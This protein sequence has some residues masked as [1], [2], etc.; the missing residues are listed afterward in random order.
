MGVTGTRMHI[1]MVEYDDAWK[2]VAGNS[3]QLDKSFFNPHDFGMTPN[4]YVFFQVRFLGVHS[5]L[6][7]RQKRARGFFGLAE[8]LQGSAGPCTE[9][10]QLEVYIP[11]G[12]ESGQEHMMRHSG[13]IGRCGARRMR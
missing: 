1:D 9:N 11:L 10:Q 8:E 12:H 5:F 4:H 7:C 3:F 6:L 2:R 13:M